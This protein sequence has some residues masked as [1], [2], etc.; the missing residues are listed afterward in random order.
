[1]VSFAR[2]STRPINVSV[3]RLSYLIYPKQMETKVIIDRCLCMDAC[4]Y[5]DAYI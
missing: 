2:V 4:M 3:E 1:M 5:M